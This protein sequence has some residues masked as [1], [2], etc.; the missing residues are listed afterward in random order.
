[1][2]KNEWKGGKTMP[3][4]WSAVRVDEAMEML[5]EPADQIKELAEQCREVVVEAR[6][7]PN[8]PQ[9]VEQRLANLC[10]SLDG[11]IGG[12]SSFSGEP[13]D[14]FIHNAIRKI[15]EAI[16]E[17]AIKD[18]LAHQRHGRQHALV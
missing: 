11:L 10:S 6:N 2:L 7:I 17:G 5:K 3:I 9:Y 4:K 13:Y 12:E 8:L 16:P 14:G 1:M 18:E 15:R